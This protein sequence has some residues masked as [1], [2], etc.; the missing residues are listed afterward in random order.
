M[1]VGAGVIGLSAAVHLY[2]RFV[3]R[4]EVTVVS[5][6]FSPNTTG[7]KAGM[8]MFPVDFND[9]DAIGSGEGAQTEEQRRVLRWAEATFKRYDDTSCTCQH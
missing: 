7:D 5:E 8:L 3:G 2:E 6:Q 1:I 4:I 9:E